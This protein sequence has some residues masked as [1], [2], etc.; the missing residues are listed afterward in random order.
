M[1]FFHHL[2]SQN[3]A[4]NGAKWV[5]SN[6]TQNDIV[7]TTVIDVYKD[8][9]IATQPCKVLRIKDNLTCFERPD[10]E[11]TFVRNDSV[12]FYD[13]T[14]N[15]FLL[16]YRF[17]AAVNDSW[18][19]PYYDA[20]LVSTNDG[21][22]DTARVTVLATSTILVNSKILR[23]LDVKYQVHSQTYTSSVV[24]RVGDVNY[25]FYYNFS[26]TFIC[27]GNFTDGLMCYSDPEIAYKGVSSHTFVACSSPVSVFEYDGNEMINVYLLDD[28]HL[29]INCRDYD[30]QYRI[31][32]MFGR[33]FSKGSSGVATSISIQEWA[34]TVYIVSIVRENGSI[35]NV[36]FIKP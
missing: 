8:T 19:I 5:F 35:Q 1:F 10:R 16:H 29:E 25:M 21:I 4:M 31:T 15:K 12:F 30:F 3:W 36:R 24:E 23:K 20:H 13:Q 18:E 27:D 33:E 11:Y 32:D 6:S 14:L 2:I 7:S 9:I 22:L 17:N 28:D 34:S 26:A